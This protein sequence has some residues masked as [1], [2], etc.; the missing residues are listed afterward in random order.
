VGNRAAV[1]LFPLASY[2]LQ[3]GFPCRRVLHIADC[4]LPIS[5]CAEPMA[6]DPPAVRRWATR[7]N[8]PPSYRVH[9]ATLD[10]R[11]S[12]CAPSPIL[13]RIVLCDFLRSGVLSFLHHTGSHTS[14]VTRFTA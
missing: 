3:P 7:L 5:D 9:G 6:G 1:S 8:C 2:S 10:R 12:S 11:R 14:P 4:G 13:L